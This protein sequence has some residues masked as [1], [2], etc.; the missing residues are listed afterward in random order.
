MIPTG[1]AL[2]A[3]I[4]IRSDNHPGSAWRM[5]VVGYCLNTQ[6]LVP[7]CLARRNEFP[8]E[9]PVL[10]FAC[11][12]EADRATARLNAF[13]ETAGPRMFWNMASGVTLA[14]TAS[15]GF[16]KPLSKS[17]CLKPI[18]WPR[19]WR[20]NSRTSED[21]ATFGPKHSV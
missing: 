21:L 17:L 2:N 5:R 4:V 9:A 7:F 8:P 12:A 18:T 1:S 20:E 10:A 19:R 13:A 3:K 11:R 15:G 16:M 14:A 6:Q